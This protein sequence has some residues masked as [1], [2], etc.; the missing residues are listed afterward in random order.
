MDVEFTS[1]VAHLVDPGTDRHE[2]GDRYATGLFAGRYLDYN[3][4]VTETGKGSEDAAVA[5]ERAISHCDAQVAI[6]CGVAGG[7]KDVALGDVVVATD[8]FG[9]EYG[10]DD[11]EFKPR[12]LVAT[13]SHPV[14]QASHAVGRSDDPDRNYELFHA[15]IAAGGVVVASRRS[16]TARF[17]QREYSQVV[18]VEMEGIAFGRALAASSG[19][20]GGIVRGISDK[21][22]G[23]AT[24][25]K[26]GMQT[27]AAVNASRHLFRILDELAPEDILGRSGVAKSE[28]AITLDDLEVDARMELDEGDPEDWYSL[29]FTMTFTTQRSQIHLATCNLARDG[30]AAQAMNL[31]VVDAIAL[32]RAANLE[33][34]T[35]TLL[36]SLTVD[37]LD[38]LR[39]PAQQPIAAVPDP[40]SF[41]IPAGRVSTDFRLITIDTGAQENQKVPLRLRYSYQLRLAQH[42]FYWCSDGPVFLRTVRF[43]AS[44]YSPPDAEHGFV[45]TLIPF[46]PGVPAATLLEPE[47]GRF[48]LHVHHAIEQGHGFAVAW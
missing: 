2:K 22:S 1:V 20:I 25:D 29:A 12:A 31:S 9:Y 26:A 46:L 37:R 48:V 45:P 34:E 5:V 21:L 40:L 14:V 42:L 17:L 8:I 18:A 23:K 38:G 43:D 44:A 36:G 30:I 4:T 11:K 3:V 13:S 32:G 15:P 6:F 35:A 47:P 33:S 28:Q 27:L 10:K 7:V 19:V 16:A 39:I 41:A 24:S